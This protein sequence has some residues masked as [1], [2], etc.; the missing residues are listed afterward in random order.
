MEGLRL[1][2]K[3]SQREGKLNGIKV[4]KT[5]NILHILFVDDVIIMTK[6]TLREWWEIDKIIK[7][8]CLASRLQVN[9]PKTTF[10]QEGLLELELSPYKSLFPYTFS[11]LVM[12]FKYLGYYLKT[13]PQRVEYWSWMLKKWKKRSVF[14][15]I[16]GCPW[17]D[18]THY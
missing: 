18:V 9:G 8:F 1:L 10:L 7:Y 5:I 3:E 11:D 17:E 2:L 6:A 16:G 12:S 15:V 4:S 14:G 13:G